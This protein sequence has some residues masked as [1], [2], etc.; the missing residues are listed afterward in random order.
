MTMVTEMTPRIENLER[1]ALEFEGAQFAISHILANLLSRLDRHEAEDCLRELQ[2]MGRAHALEL[3][4]HRLTGYLDELE[5]MK[6]AANSVR[7]VT[8]PSLRAVS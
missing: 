6:V 4:E 7:K 1:A 2:D 3:G 5:A 8:P